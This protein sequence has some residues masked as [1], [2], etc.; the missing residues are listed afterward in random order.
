M[1]LITFLLCHVAPHSDQA[2]KP[3]Q[4]IMGITPPIGL[5]EPQPAGSSFVFS[6][7]QALKQIF[8]GN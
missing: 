4:D 6:Q 3:D 2:L 8:E 1:T 7:R 5:H